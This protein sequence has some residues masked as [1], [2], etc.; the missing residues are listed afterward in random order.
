MRVLV[1]HAHPLATSFNRCVLERALAGL[2]TAGHDVDVVDLYADGFDPVMTEVERTTDFDPHTA[3]PLVASYVARLL[4][5][6]ALVFVHP[7]WWGG[8]PAILKG[9]FDRVLRAGVAYDRVRGTNR[10]RGR[11]R[12]VRHLVMVTTHGSS[13]IVNAVQ[14]EPGRHTVMRQLRLMCAR[15]CRRTWLPFY[16]S[17]IAED[18]ER[19]VFLDRVEDTMSRL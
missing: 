7:T 15:R 10:V 14:G 6:D 2:A 9:W 3:D 4:R 12:N 8:Q 5:C 1:V 13:K 18:A 17:D 19:A 16:G 11:L